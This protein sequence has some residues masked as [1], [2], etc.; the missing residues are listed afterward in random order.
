MTIIQKGKYW[1]MHV[2]KSYANC[3][4]LH[5]SYLLFSISQGNCRSHKPYYKR[6]LVHVEDSEKRIKESY[7]LS[8]FFKELKWFAFC[9]AYSLQLTPEYLELKL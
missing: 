5:T 3:I 6:T 8:F 4:L 2:S 7:F 9:I 1:G